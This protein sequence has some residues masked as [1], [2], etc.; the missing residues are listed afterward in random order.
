MQSKRLKFMLRL[1]CARIRLPAGLRPDPLR[2]LKRSPDFLAAIRGP[3][4]RERRERE[5]KGGEGSL[6][7]NRAADYLTPAMF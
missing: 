2:E 7:L 6:R 4:L 1:K 5:E 3:L